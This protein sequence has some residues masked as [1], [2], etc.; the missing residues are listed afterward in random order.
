MRLCGRR[1]S[2]DEQW[3]ERGDVGGEKTGIWGRVGEVMG[4]MFVFKQWGGERMGETSSPCALARWEVHGTHGGS[5]QLLGARVSQEPMFGLQCTTLT[6]REERGR[7]RGNPARSVPYSAEQVKH[8]GRE[9]R[10]SSEG[11]PS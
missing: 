9:P 11:G 1:C 7:L 2:V 6:P 5:C 3:Y 8:A 4:A 10:E